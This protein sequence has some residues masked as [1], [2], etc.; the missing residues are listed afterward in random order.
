[1]GLFLQR[2]RKRNL[3]RNEN[4]TECFDSEFLGPAHTVHKI[5]KVRAYR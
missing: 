4:C 5:M 2:T 1:M 3:A